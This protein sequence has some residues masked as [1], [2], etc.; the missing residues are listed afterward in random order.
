M[1]GQRS[2]EMRGWEHL[3]VPRVAKEHFL[4]R[5]LPLF[6][7]PWQSFSVTYSDLKPNFHPGVLQLPVSLVAKQDDR[8]ELDI[9]RKR[10]GFLCSPCLEA[11]EGFLGNGIIHF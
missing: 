11:E 10:E 7:Q 1:G 5:V 8:M 9:Q 4:I 3:S 6:Q 2:V